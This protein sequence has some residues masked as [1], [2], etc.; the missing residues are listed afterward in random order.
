M[1]RKS[2]LAV[3]VLAGLGLLVAPVGPAAANH[4]PERP[5]IPEIFTVDLEAVPHDPAE[6][7]GSDA[8]GFA[9]L[10]RRGDEVQT[11]LVA[12]GTS[13]RLPHAV[14]IHGKEEAV[15]ECPSLAA[16]GDD[17]LID[18][19]DGLPAYGGILVSLTTE[20]GTGAALDGDAL[21]LDRFP[22][23]NG[24]GTFQYNRRIAMPGVADRLDELHI[25]VHGEDLNDN[26][27]YDLG[28]GVSSLSPLLGADVQI[29]LE[30]ELP[31]ACGT[32]G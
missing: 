28:P 25:V 6:D 9:L 4:R 24:G 21:A 15:A 7:S 14:H 13:P 16:A 27:T 31:V 2:M 8:G 17:G 12:R 29:P 11:V 26:G 20:G 1:I 10:V 18:T 32:I 23:A 5:A 30:A 19:V 22:V 3:P